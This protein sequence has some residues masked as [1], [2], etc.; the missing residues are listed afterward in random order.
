M[1]F[2]KIIPAFILLSIIC[3]QNVIGQTTVLYAEL[4]SKLCGRLITLNKNNIFSITKVPTG[5]TITI[6]YKNN[7]TG[8]DTLKKI[9]PRGGDSIGINFNNSDLIKVSNF[10]VY[11]NSSDHCSFTIT[12]FD[13]KGKIPPIKPDPKEQANKQ[14]E[15][16]SS[17]QLQKVAYQD[18]INFT[19]ET[20]SVL[21]L[22]ILSYYNNTIISDKNTLINAYGNNPFIKNS[23]GYIS[24]LTHFD[25]KI[26]FNN[27]N[28]ETAVATG[29]LSGLASLGGIDITPYVQATADFL[30]ERVK[31]EL[32]L[33]FID[34]FKTVIDTIPEIKALFPKT[35]QVFTTN[36]PFK[37]PTLGS[38]YKTAFMQDMEQMIYN[39]EIMVNTLNKYATIKNS[40][41][42]IA[43]MA[44]YRAVDLASKGSHAADII[45]EIG[46]YYGKDSLANDA[47]TI[48]KIGRDKITVG[49]T[50]MLASVLSNNFKK[51]PAPSDDSSPWISVENYAQMSVD[52]K[53]IFWGLIYQQNKALFNNISI[54]NTSLISDDDKG[55][56]NTKTIVK[57]GLVMKQCL[58]VLNNMHQQI[59]QYEKIISD[60][61]IDDKTKR[62][63]VLEAF[64]RN[65]EN[66]I[67]TIDIIVRICYTGNEQ[68]YV[69][70]K[71]YS[72]IKPSL[73]DVSEI[74]NGLYD[75][76]YAKVV[77]NSISLF[78]TLFDQP[79]TMSL[80]DLSALVT[81]IQNIKNS[82]NSTLNEDAVKTILKDKSLKNMSPSDLLKEIEKN[83]ADTKTKSTLTKLITEL[84][85]KEEQ[86][87]YNHTK[88]NNQK[89][90]RNLT[91]LTNFMV[92]V[93]EADSASQIKT[94]IERYADPAGSY[95]L[96]RYSPSSI[97]LNAYPGLYAGWENDFKRAS[98][99]VGS[100]GVT[101]PIGI[102]INWGTSWNDKKWKK[103]IQNNTRLSPD[104]FHYHKGLLKY[105]S[106]TSHSIFISVVD[107]GA[108]L[109][110][111]WSNDT[112]DLP[113]K[114][115]LPQIFSP[116]IFYVWGIKN[117]PLAL[118]FGGQYAPQ[119][120]SISSAGNTL[121]EAGVFR[122]TAA[123][124]IDIPVIHLYR[125]EE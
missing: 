68:A 109:S 85:T 31:E 9:L 90:I 21:L 41:E 116:G 118:K 24:L 52:S 15:D 16:L 115:T 66:L 6:Q 57:T 81:D 4:K 59:N 33:A 107:I 92:D 125:K 97:S 79:V 49:N 96:K 23:N 72:K 48:G 22:G 51:S 17:A 44:T 113:E 11:Y 12:R 112:L 102:S 3:N 67:N 64:T 76:D 29:G 54:N 108:V 43:F 56:I 37:I 98:T 63:R 69:D 122:F 111:R 25:N 82:I 26:K 101:A 73:S 2:K 55:I 70:S 14:E 40:P 89:L 99:N 71:F 13:K 61:S 1:N 42:F 8:K 27:K 104:N 123:I 100:F 117:T 124:T 7:N 65:S 47:T 74:G 93:I 86:F 94:I 35:Y 38:T 80:A 75:K 32:T 19:T 30:V 36:D 77:L 45:S 62:Q 50:F 28:I 103:R 78:S 105:Y 46:L 119:L 121:S 110:F 91:N 84:I 34:K 114:I 53:L 120:R 88:I 18:A 83:I 95:Q 20:D 58:T 87:P 106:G 39:F 60:T 10:T 5:R